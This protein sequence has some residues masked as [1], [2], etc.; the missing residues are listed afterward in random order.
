VIAFFVAQVGHVTL[1]SRRP[2][3]N[4]T[5]WSQRKSRPPLHGWH[6]GVPLSDL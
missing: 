5:T 4:G 2:L 3:I 1:P 6:G